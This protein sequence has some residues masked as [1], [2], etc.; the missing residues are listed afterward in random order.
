[1][2]HF[3][4]NIVSALYYT[5]IKDRLYCDVEDSVQ[6]KSAQYVLEQIFYIITRSVASIVP[7][8]VEELYMNLPNK[9][10]ESYFQIN[11]VNIPGIWDSL[12]VD[13]LMKHLLA[14]KKEI[15]K[16]CGASTLDKCVTVSVSE[17]VYSL[18]RVSK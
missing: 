5:E 13:N 15:N 14:I 1:M 3:L 4:S 7:H 6:R 16:A 18:L 11:E 10:C 12:E 17:E 9:K 2:L 8:L